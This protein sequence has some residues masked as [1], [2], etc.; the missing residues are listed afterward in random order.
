MSPLWPTACSGD[1]SDKSEGCSLQAREGQTMVSFTLYSKQ[2]N[3]DWRPQ[4]TNWLKMLTELELSLEMF[5]FISILLLPPQGVLLELS[6][7]PSMVA[8]LGP[9]HCTSSPAACRGPQCCTAVSMCTPSLMWRLPSS[10][11]VTVI[12]LIEHL[13]AYRAHLYT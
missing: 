11:L 9:H 5:T 6:S 3:L 7:K 12:I 4:T 2:I 10:L 13:T 8:A 1:G